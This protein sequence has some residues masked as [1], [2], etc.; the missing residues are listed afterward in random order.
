[1][2]GAN[3]PSPVLPDHNRT[4]EGMLYIRQLHES[5]GKGKRFFIGAHRLLIFPF[6]HRITRVP[7]VSYDHKDLFL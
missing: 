4:V 3:P 5:R 6:Q 1:M 2:G 7:L